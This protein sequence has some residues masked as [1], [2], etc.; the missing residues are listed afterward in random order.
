VHLDVDGRSIAF[1]VAPPPD[2]DRAARAAAAH[3]HGGGP[4]E[5][6]APMPGAVLAVHVAVGDAVEAGDPIVTLEAM[7]M[8]HVVAA[9]GAG[10]VAELGVGVGD[11][12]IRGQA[13]AAIEA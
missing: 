1:R 8:E 4:A 3:V 12:V 6:T 10:R 9:R 2:V 7:K 13:L 5:V 11:Q